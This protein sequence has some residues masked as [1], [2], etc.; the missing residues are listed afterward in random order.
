MSG[1]TERFARLADRLERVETSRQEPVAALDEIKS[2]IVAIRHEIAGRPVPKV[3]HLE[4]QVAELARRLETATHSES[5]GQALAE[6][7]AQVAHIASEVERSMPRT[8]TLKQ[9]EENLARLQGFLTDS[10]EESVE[11]ARSA[12]REAVREIAAGPGDSDLVRALKGDLE[13]IR[14]AATD[15][16]QRTQDTLGSVH[17]TLARVVERLT[18]LEHESGDDTSVMAR[19]P[20]KATGTYGAAPPVPRAEPGPA[21][22][23]WSG[24]AKLPEDNRPLEPGS[25]KP[26][27]AALRELARA[28]SDGQR[29]KKGD[30]KADFIAAARRAAQAAAAEAA[31]DVEEEPAEEGKPGTFARIGQAIRRRKRP[32]LL[33]AAALVLAISA[34]QLF[35]EHGIRSVDLSRS[36]ASAEPSVGDLP[37]PPPVGQASVA[38]LPSTPTVPK[39]SESALVAPPPDGGSALAFA[40]PDGVGSR[41]GDVPASPPSTGFTSAPPPPASDMP[42]PAAGTAMASL[43]TETAPVVSTTVSADAP[44]GPPK[45]REA[46][47]AGD[48]S[49][50]FEIAARYA[51][52]NGVEPDLARAAEW[53]R[54]S[55]EAG[56][57]VAQYRLGSLYERGQGVA[58]NR[59]EAVTWYQRAADQGNV[60]AMHNLAVMMSEGVDGA[61]DHGKAF[62]WF[63]AAANC[64]V[65][66][67][68][69][70]LGVIYARGLGPAQDLVESYKWFAVAAAGG[71]KDATV[72]RDEVAKVLSPDDLAKARAIVQAWRATPVITEANTVATPPGGWGEASGGVT[73]AN[74]QALVKKIQTLLAE[75]GY[76]PGPLDGYEG[77]KTREAVKA[78]Q[79]KIGLTEN[80]RI[81][82]D[83]VAALAAPQT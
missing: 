50:A 63:L 3:D 30:R 10:R 26:D 52:G 7:E 70:N 56:I 42:A 61:P 44:I 64:G 80:G 79:R 27:L 78:F 43:D 20:A 24:T 67:S 83:L 6:L 31:S 37:V 4:S 41:F 2:E 15:A 65:K 38:Q 16:D 33:A 5:E 58:R 57:A 51:E 75:Q 76:D 36:T 54:R 40:A 14:S 82:G 53:Y 49:A 77:P 62:E 59:T 48:P 45:L 69:Y 13:N 9:V 81:S 18:R 55:A 60:G 35:G 73:E 1:L 21:A 19:E 28:A 11:A 71:D 68:Q 74:R 23:V 12:A 66:D 22:P 8:A 29:D 17:E 39:V 46:A 47:A 72:R 32:L 34:L 25:G